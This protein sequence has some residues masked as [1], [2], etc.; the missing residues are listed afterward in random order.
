MSRGAR[1]ESGEEEVSGPTST[2]SQERRRG[3]TR[4]SPTG[5][6]SELFSGGTSNTT[7]A[8]THPRNKAAEVYGSGKGTRVWGSE[9]EN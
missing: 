3:S 2:A 4:S 5:I 8:S 9:E 1:E 7:S 6:L